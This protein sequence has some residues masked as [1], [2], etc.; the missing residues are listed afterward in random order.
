MLRYPLELGYLLMIVL[1]FASLD[2]G[3]GL[4][5]LESSWVESKFATVAFAQKGSGIDYYLYL[6]FG[7]QD[8]FIASLLHC[9]PLSTFF[10]GL[11]NFQFPLG[12]P[13]L[14]SSSVGH[15]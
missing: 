11:T 7:V 1:P 3:E 12:K 9:F 15:Q 5:G 14:E 2:E 4:V 8:D 10:I 13:L 6:V